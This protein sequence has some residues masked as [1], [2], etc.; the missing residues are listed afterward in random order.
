MREG[1]VAAGSSCLALE[2][3]LLFDG[4]ALAAGLDLLSAG[5]APAVDGLD[6]HRE[7]DAPQLPDALGAWMSGN[8][9]TPEPVVF[10]DHVLA[11]NAAL[12]ATLPQHWDVVVL[13][14][15]GDGLQFMAETLA[16]RHDIPAIHLLTHGTDSGL[17]LGNRWVDAAT[18]AQ[19]SVHW[20][21][22]GDALS[23][24]GDLVLYGCRLA[25]QPQGQALLEGLAALTGA[26]VAAS[27]DLT[28]AVQRGGDWQL[29]YVRGAVE[30]P[31]LDPGT[32]YDG[33]LAAPTLTTSSPADN[34]V[35]V[36]VAANFTLTF[37]Q[38]VAVGSGTIRLYQGNG[39]LVESFNVL[40]GVGSSGGTVSVSNAVVT[41]NPAANLASET[42][43]YLLADA[44][45]VTDGAG[46]GYAG[47]S[48]TTS[49]NFVS[50]DA[51]APT[52]ASSDPADGAS[53]VATQ[54]ILTLTFSET[55]QAGSGTLR[56]YQGNGTLVESFN[57]ATGVGSAGGTITFDGS[58][59]VSVNAA[60]GFASET[61]HYLLIDSGAIQDSHGN[62]Y[63]G[64]S[65]RTTLNF[66]SIDSVAPMLSSSSP[67]DNA[68][69]I[70]V[71]SDLRLTFNETVQAGS[72]GTLA[73]YRA[74]G[75]VVE[76]FS[77]ASG[78]GD[79][80]GSVVFDGSTGVT[81]SPGVDLT[82]ATGYYLLV[83]SGAITDSAGNAYAGLSQSTSLNFTSAD[84]VAPILLSSDPADGAS[85]VAAQGVLRLTFN[86]EVRAGS[87][88]VILYRQDGL[89]VER[90]DAASGVGSAGGRLS[91]NGTAVVSLT[92]GNSLA[93]G[94]GYYLALETGAVQDL[95]GNEHVGWSDATTLN[96]VTADTLAPTLTSTSPVAGAV[97]VDPGSRIV[98]TFDEPVRAGTGMVTL[99]TTSGWVA[100][101][102]DIAIGQGSGGGQVVAGP[103]N[104]LTLTPGQRLSSATGYAL[105]VAPGVVVD[106]AGNA[107][108]GVTD[109][110]LVAFSVADV[111]A[112]TLL[113]SDP[114]SGAVGVQGALRLTFS[115]PVQAGVGTASL[116]TAGGQLVERFDLAGGLGSAGGQ[117]L[118]S[119]AVLTLTP[120]QVLAS[121]TVHTLVV[122]AGALRDSAGNA[123]AGLSGESGLS[124]TSADVVAPT[125]V[126]ATPASGAVDVAL[127]AVVTLTFSEVVQA[128]SGLMWLEDSAGAV[129]ESFDAASGVG[130]AGG[131]VRF[132]GAAGVALEPFG[133][134]RSGNTYSV[135]LAAGAVIDRWGNPHAGVSSGTWT[136]RTESLVL[137][138]VV[139]ESAESV[140]SGEDAPGAEGGSASAEAAPPPQAAPP[141]ADD[142]GAAI[143]AEAGLPV[144]QGDRAAMADALREIGAGGLVQRLLGSGQPVGQAVGSLF[145]ELLGRGST[146]APGELKSLLGRFGVGQDG[147]LGYLMALDRVNKEV[148]TQQL[149]G[150]LEAL[151]RDPAQA[152]VLGDLLARADKAPRVVSDGVSERLAV[153][154][155]VQDYGDPSISTLN[156]P[157]H[158][159]REVARQL[160]ERFGYRSNVLVNPGRAA[161]L[162]TLARAASR[163]SPED[164]LVVYYAG[165][166]FLREDNGEGYWLPADARTDSARN[167]IS[168]SDVA[169]FLKRIQAG[170]ILLISDSCYSGSLT[171]GSP[172]DHEGV[173]TAQ[174]EQHPRAVTVIS[175]GG[176]EPVRDDGS[177]GHSVFADQLLR[178]LEA[179]AQSRQGQ[180]LFLDV[181]DGVA[182]VATQVP[183]YGT[184][185]SAGHQP[186]VDIVFQVQ[187]R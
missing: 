125:L 82:T 71:G 129:F 134:L 109:P 154:I 107:F 75:V 72:S 87:G 165:H 174:Q 143:A 36:A 121:E 35:D 29:E 181:R 183:Q 149:G 7:T 77:V 156:T 92:P 136:F 65:V 157:V 99:Q 16:H 41:V 57:V 116:M 44:G 100:E 120:G 19:Q 4:A 6:L 27:D 101:T 46:N 37:D 63:A 43:H 3:R 91:F 167:W 117:A 158:D 74:D 162:D 148:R 70:A 59:G 103:D 132:D 53:G 137:P 2:R 73:L 90:F 105:L 180:E 175:S 123:F 151:D 133:E 24:D 111:V 79:A 159:A 161:I 13:P 64:I 50:V 51:V 112:P 150:A 34:A 5:D 42:S 54:A 8:Q 49:L 58:T 98:L 33:V 164:E 12:M 85:G 52:L 153:M 21:V 124:F 39:T 18:L 173:E 110:A 113:S 182:R 108:A 104:T 146:L 60:A 23:Q 172:A 26:D 56:L 160:E 17:S 45:I 88:A 144:D 96:F 30:T 10:V 106:N 170:R 1:Q 102:F 142:G 141:P 14:A 55:V 76:R 130:S 93:S 187:G 97:N 9:E 184:I 131:R 186:G 89:E 178:S 95:S 15:Q 69:N 114:A 176:E 61:A 122:E 140:E 84:A 115:E 66:I 40:T 22:V 138:F 62:S 32:A 127:D 86:E 152:S 179:V 20:G 48:S 67:G 168:T 147:M 94:S 118:I 78:S 119:S 31:L 83:D 80:G 169:A 145:G 185:A 11:T 171:R 68:V 25:A 155:A 128:G 163:L 28:G 135:V 38:S 177:G 166:G 47:I 139:A 81:L 126:A